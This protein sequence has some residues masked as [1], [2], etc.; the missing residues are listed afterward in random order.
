MAITA[1]FHIGSALEVT[2]DQDGNQLAVT[3]NAAGA[4]SVFKVNP[5]SAVLIQG[6]APTVANTNVIHVS[7]GGGAD[8]LDLVDHGALPRGVIFG[9]R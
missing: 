6:D 3:D 9:W 5:T 1:T 2:G 7:G 4:I 8:N